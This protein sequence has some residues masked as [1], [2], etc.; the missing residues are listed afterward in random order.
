MLG[1]FLEDKEEVNSLSESL[2]E[3]VFIDTCAS[4]G[5]FLVSRNGER[6]LQRVKVLREPISLGLTDMN[7]PMMVHKLGSYKDWQNIM[8]CDTTRKSIIAA[9]KITARGYTI[10]ID[11]KVRILRGSR[12]I[13][14]CAKENSMPWVYLKDLLGLLNASEQD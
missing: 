1:F 5:I 10:V 8:V 13:M 7:L 9:D 12:H 3:R 6:Y 2:E 11:G 14:T 4:Q